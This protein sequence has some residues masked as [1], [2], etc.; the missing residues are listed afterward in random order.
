MIN[1]LTSFLRA[2]TFKKD[3]FILIA[4]TII[5]G[6]LFSFGLAWAAD[7]YFGDTVSG[8]VGE[9]GEYDLILHVREDA[10]EAALPE[11]KR[12]L[13]ESLPGTTFKQAP[14]V[15]G[16]ANF[17]LAF[18]DDHKNREVMEQI[19][20]YFETIPGYSGTTLIMSP[21]LTIRGV[22]FG[23]KGILIGR[24]TELP[25]IKY[26][27]VSG[28]NVVAALHEEVD[29]PKLTQK[30]EDILAEYQTVEVRY[31]MGYQ[32]EN[33]SELG[34]RLVL[35]IQDELKPEL[36]RDV[37]LSGETD[38]LSAFMGTLVEMK[39]FLLG[40][41]SEVKIALDSA[42]PL[43]VGERVVLQ[44]ASPQPLVVGETLRPDN[45]VIDI[46]S[47]H[48][49]TAKGMITQ[50]DI[51]AVAPE[52]LEFSADSSGP[53][54]TKAY[55]LERGTKVGALVGE[56]TI[57]NDRYALMLAIDESVKLL[58]ELEV[59]AQEADQTGRH[60]LETLDAFEATLDQ[61]AQVE[62]TLRLVNASLDGPLGQLGEI[63]IAEIVRALQ[64]TS[65]SIELLLASMGVV[66]TPSTGHLA[67][68]DQRLAEVADQPGLDQVGSGLSEVKDEVAAGA[69]G[70]DDVLKNINPVA[71]ILNGFKQK[72]DQFTEQVDNFGSLA[73]NSNVVYDGM[74]DIG[75]ATSS[76]LSA[77][78]T[79]DVNA[80][81][82]DLKE[83]TSRLAAIGELDTNLVRDQMSD[84][85][86]T[87]PELTDEQIGRS[88]RLIDSYIGGEVIPGE[89]IQLLID[90]KVS[91][92]QLLPIVEDISSTTD[93][94][95]YNMP[96]GTLEPDTM[97][98]VFSILREVRS[99]IAGLAAI[100]F[101]LIVLWLDH[102]TIISALRKLVPGKKRFGGRFAQLIQRLEPDLA[103]VYAAVVG[104]V[105]LSGTY[106]LAGGAIPYISLA[107]LL[108]LGCL[109]GLGTATL[110]ERISPVSE[111][112]LLAGL[113][114][115]L[116][117]T[118]IMRELVIP[119]GRPG[120]A[121]LL[122]RRN[123]RFK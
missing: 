74:S 45:I 15:V 95:I 23:A 63:N 103:G 9:V 33:L 122:N 119:E 48:G 88:V 59:M 51:S 82:R 17:L 53:V 29:M 60:L 55:R 92:K 105:I 46:M 107:H 86:Q 68:V 64:N 57:R 89:R 106:W 81:R 102:A 50:G 61:I 8:L 90:G 87:L 32:I 27:F 98:V 76:V 16:K 80:L 114:L 54:V 24:L 66:S 4:V 10:K 1:R 7:L 115:G 34:S 112:E 117:K 26:A 39:R 108:V 58:S 79:V 31:P 78:E 77:M 5:I 52:V 44:G 62:E 97:G 22:Q 20:S 72:I 123:L 121:N 49:N 38:D 43:R 19:D 120:V 113:S 21:T 75:G 47:I 13:S 70:L 83:I 110:A 12:I 85:R 18:P 100:V 36:V 116:R 94:S 3:I 111:T 35:A 118:D 42:A 37:T 109:A 104:G 84:V 91:E 14:T 96:I 69:Q 99:T 6:G 73:E 30:V 25:E 2:D 101:T 67:D 65:T 28:G 41:A 56:T 40:Y 93:F 71:Q 11:L